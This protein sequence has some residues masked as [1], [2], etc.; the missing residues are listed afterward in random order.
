MFLGAG[1][2]IFA[3]MVGQE[4]GTDMWIPMD[5]FL[6]TGVGLVFLAIVALAKTSGDVNGREWGERKKRGR[7]FCLGFFS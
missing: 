1:N 2:I 4:A 6:I 5:G 7:F 3:P